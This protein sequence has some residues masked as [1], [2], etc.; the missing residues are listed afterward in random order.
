M[1]GGDAWDACA[2]AYDH[3][4]C[5]CDSTK[6]VGGSAGSQAGIHF[7]ILGVAVIQGQPVAVADTLWD[8][9]EL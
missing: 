4:R 6:P 9:D 3:G 8:I 5:D 7:H 1:S 2:D